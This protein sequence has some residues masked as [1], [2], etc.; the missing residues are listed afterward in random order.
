VRYGT[1]GDAREPSQS[2]FTFV[3]MVFILLMW[4]HLPVPLGYIFRDFAVVRLREMMLYLPSCWSVIC[5]SG[6]SALDW[7]KIAGRP[8]DSKSCGVS[9]N[10]ANVVAE[11][12]RSWN[13]N[14]VVE[15]D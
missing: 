12:L 11:R 15:S 2:S 4:S 5:I 3:A 10:N 7:H 6:K 1:T 8:R 9:S 13:A 14:A